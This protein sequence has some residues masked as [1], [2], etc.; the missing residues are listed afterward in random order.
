MPTKNEIDQ[1]IIDIIVS[2]HFRPMGWNDVHA[3]LFDF[4]DSL[5]FA[6]LVIE[7]EDEFLISIPDDYPWSENTSVASV[8]S[9][10]IGAI[11]ARSS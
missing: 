3:G 2:M 1:K 4:M 10:V 11:N 6:E 7:I 8:T 5:E 9:V